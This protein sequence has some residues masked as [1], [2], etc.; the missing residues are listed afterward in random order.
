[1]DYINFKYIR[2]YEHE[3]RIGVLIEFGSESE[4]TSGVSDVHALLNDIAM[5]IAACTPADIEDL[6]DQEFLKYPEQKVSDVLTA[7]S[8]SISNRIEVLRFVRWEVDCVSGWPPSE[9]SSGAG[10]ISVVK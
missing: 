1:M 8:K 2:S 3:R 7:L 4:I 6:L 9:P 10:K 5:H